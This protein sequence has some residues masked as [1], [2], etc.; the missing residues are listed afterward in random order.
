MAPERI[1]RVK[2]KRESG[3]LYFVKSDEEGWLCIYKTELKRGGK[4]KAQLEKEKIES[5]KN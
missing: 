2:V 3:F 5:L 1:A 4:T